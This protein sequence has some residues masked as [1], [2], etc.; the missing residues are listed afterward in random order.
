MR[1]IMVVV[2]VALAIAVPTIIPFVSLIGAFCFSIL[3]LMVPVGIEVLT[4]WD[5]GFGK[6]NWK[7]FKNVIVVLTGLLALIFGS[8]SAIVDIVTLYSTPLTNATTSLVN[9]TGS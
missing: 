3:G 6:F 4:F 5:K 7:I 1:T 2:C 8:K 9:S